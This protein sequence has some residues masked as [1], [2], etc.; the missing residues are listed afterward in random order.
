[1]NTAGGKLFLMYLHFNQLGQYSA[2]FF[3]LEV[4]GGFSQLAALSEIYTI[5][6]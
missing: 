6:T 3:L 5:M 1:M 4:G 2:N